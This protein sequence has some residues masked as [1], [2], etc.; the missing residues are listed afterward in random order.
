M[1]RTQSLYDWDKKKKKKTTAEE[2]FNGVKEKIKNRICR[3]D[4]WSK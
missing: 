3:D 2:I 4:G 1:Q